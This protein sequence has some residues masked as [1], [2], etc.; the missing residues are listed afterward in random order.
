MFSNFAHAKTKNQKQ[1]THKKT[2]RNKELVQTNQYQKL[3]QDTE[4]KYDLPKNILTALIQHESSFNPKAVNDDTKIASY[5]L[6]QITY[7]TAKRFCSIRSRRELMHG[8]TNIRCTAKIL[9]NNI[10]KYGGLHP[11]LAAYRAG[12]P[13][14]NKSKRLRNCTTGDKKYVDGVI[15]KFKVIKKREKLMAYSDE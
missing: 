7:P 6:G 1:K 14:S 8:H 13:C 15:R 10:E 11:A 4:K 3:I 9:K 2:K 5:G 12:S